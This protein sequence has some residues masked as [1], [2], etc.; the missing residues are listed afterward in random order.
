MKDGEVSILGG[1]SDKEYSLGISGFPGLTNI[2]LLGY[3]F[4]EKDRTSTDN[5]ILIAMIP[6]IVRAPD[7]STMGQEGILAGTERVVRV[8]R[9]VDGGTG[10]TG[11]SAT[12]GGP[13]TAPSAPAP[14]MYPQPGNAPVV[15]PPAGY[16]RVSPPANGTSPQ[17]TTPT[18]P[19]GARPSPV[20]PPQQ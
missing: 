9:R 6:H 19:P 8:E 2:P 1:L 7:T 14:M 20:N 13:S 3:L 17:F 11:G 12:G 5:E 18:P 4:G 15:N 10:S 16:P